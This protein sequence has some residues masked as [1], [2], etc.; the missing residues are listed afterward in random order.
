M[1]PGRGTIRLRSV[2]CTFP[3]NKRLSSSLPVL[4][5]PIRNNIPYSLFSFPLAP[6]PRMSARGANVTAR[7]SCRGRSA[8]RIVKAIMYSVD[9]RI[10]DT[11]LL[12]ALVLAQ[13]SASEGSRISAKSGAARVSPRARA[14]PDKRQR[15]LTRVKRAFRVAARP[16]S[17][18]LNYRPIRY[19]DTI[20]Y[21]RQR[22]R[23][24][25]RGEERGKGT[26]R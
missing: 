14:R 15:I 6:L 2:G 11:L 12:G 16:G 17:A 26:T 10:K 1:V 18:G 9:G 19:H 8:F 13:R 23:R 20:L 24:R 4:H 3:K 25:R 5:T 22:G 21:T 7:F